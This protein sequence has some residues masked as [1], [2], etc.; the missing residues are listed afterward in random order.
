M[1]RPGRYL[2]IPDQPA[3]ALQLGA[4]GAGAA[5]RRGGVERDGAPATGRLRLAGQYLVPGPHPRLC[6]AD[7]ADIEV[8]IRPA[9]AEQLAAAHARGGG[10]QPGGEESVVGDRGQER[11]RLFGRPHLEFWARDGRHVGKTRRVAADQAQTLGV[12]QG[13]A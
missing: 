8:N 13:F 2:H 9:K 1:V 5:P 12:S 10:E 7:A 4:C 3:V 11:P 6:D